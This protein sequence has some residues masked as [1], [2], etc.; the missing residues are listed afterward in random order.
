MG[1]TPPKFVG[2]VVLDPETLASIVSQSN[3]TTTSSTPATPATPFVA[4]YWL[5]IYET[6]A[7]TT[8][9][10]VQAINGSGVMIGFENFFNS[11]FSPSGFVTTNFTMETNSTVPLG[12]MAIVNW[13]SG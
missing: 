2:P 8:A 11:A 3:Q 12:M 9:D 1:L 6:D 7:F 4:E 5:P 10:I 13:I